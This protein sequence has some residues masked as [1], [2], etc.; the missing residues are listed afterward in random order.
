[1]TGVSDRAADEPDLRL[2]WAW[3]APDGGRGGGGGVP[4][5][6]AS[7]VSVTRTLDS[8][9]VPQLVTVTVV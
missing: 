2:T 6:S 3:Y 9:T 5:G 4:A 8:T 1:M 7:Q